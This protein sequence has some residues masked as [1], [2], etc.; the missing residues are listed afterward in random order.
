MLRRMT[1]LRP[2]H[3]ALI[4]RINEVFEA[5]PDVLAAWVEGS[6]GRGT[7]DAGSDLDVHLA[8]RDEAFESYGK[9]A[10]ALLARIA[11]PL[12]FL[13]TTFGQV[14]VLASTL[15]GPVRLDL[16]LEPLGALATNP[17][18]AGFRT[19]FDRADVASLLA[20][21]PEPTFSAAAQLQGLIRGYF[22]GGMWPVR[23]WMRADWGSL[24]MNDLRLVY[25]CIVPALLIAEGSPEFYREPHSRARFLA[26]ANLAAIND[27]IAQLSTA[28]TALPEV[29]E[30]R[31]ATAQ[32]ALT[33]LLWRALRE[34]AAVTG[35]DY[36]DATEQEF[37]DYF[38]RSG[39]PV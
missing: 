7:H 34:A 26:P 36:P 9:P 2:D 28:Y 29:D 38:V 10:P 8:L 14:C 32:A 6:V 24:L 13:D 12:G 1:T 4:D 20:Q 30:A 33:R 27:V 19:I 31:L 35:V 39:I 18:H 37:R 22:F 3:Q 21:S 11:P 5:D 23:M 16:Y 17:R 25:D 15:S